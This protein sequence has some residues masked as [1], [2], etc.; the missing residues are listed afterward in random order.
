MELPLAGLADDVADV[1]ALNLTRADARVDQ[2]VEPG[3]R[4]QLRARPL[5]LAEL[6]HADT[7]DRDPSHA[8]IVSDVA[9]SRKGA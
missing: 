1:H 9:R 6:R 5:V 7:D 8:W 3:L 4:E 2:G